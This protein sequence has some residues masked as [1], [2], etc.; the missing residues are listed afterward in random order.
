MQSLPINPFDAAV[1]FCL[2]VAVVFGFRSGLLRSLATI[3]GYLAAAPVVVTL[4]PYVAPVLADRLQMPAAQILL[5]IFAIFV[6]FGV[7]LSALLRRLVDM[8]V[9]PQVSAPDRVA[10][11]V[12]GAV[13][14][15]LL[16]VVMVLIFDRIIPADRQPA[17][18]EGSHLRPLLSRAGRLGLKSLPPEV[19]ESIDRLKRAH[20]I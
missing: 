4:V 3:F 8:A 9:G 2:I 16:A 13:R 17:F 5:V 19:S 6:L 11:A 14:I 10:G 20:G 7:V 1:Y 12:L 18:L 15:S